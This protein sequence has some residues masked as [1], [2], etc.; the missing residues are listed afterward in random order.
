M[1][2]LRAIKSGHSVSAFQKKIINFF[3]MDL[4]LVFVRKLESRP[5][6]V[7]IGMSE[8]NHTRYDYYYYENLIGKGNY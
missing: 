2:H 4:H 5:S 8:Q 6:F 7:G 3:I 1:A